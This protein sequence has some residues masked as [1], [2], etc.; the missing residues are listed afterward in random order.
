VTEDLEIS[1]G[2]ELGLV[3][4]ALNTVR[5]FFGMVGLIPEGEKQESSAESSDFL[6]EPVLTESVD[7]RRKVRNFSLGADEVKF[8]I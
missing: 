4:A 8:E 5:D 3:L 7:F 1:I 6:L 2:M